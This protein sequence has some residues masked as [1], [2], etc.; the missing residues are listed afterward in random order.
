MS[1][2]EGPLTRD[3]LDVWHAFKRASEA[4]T[5]AVER[6]LLATTGLTGAEFGVLDRLRLSDGAMRQA[7]LAA[8]MG[9]QKSRLSHQLSRMQD[10]GLVTR[11]LHTPS[12]ATAALT[13]EGSRAIAAALPVH[14]RAVRAHLVDALP[15]AQRETLL[16]AL[17]SLA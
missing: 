5:A 9:W 3:E 7:D 2:D 4:V 14:A 12:S 16:A 1:D 10:R 8:S 11:E 15:V 6:D 17:R 13:T